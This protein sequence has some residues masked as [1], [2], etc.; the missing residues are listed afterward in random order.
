MSQMHKYIANCLSQHISV[1]YPWQVEKSVEVHLQ[2][3]WYT[4]YKVSSND[5][6]IRSHEFIIYS[7]S[8]YASRLYL[9]ISKTNRTNSKK[10]K[11]ENLIQ[12]V[13]Y[14]WLYWLD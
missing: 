2:F 9:L 11:V 14:R 5:I 7:V 3:K 12:K 10:N 4:V 8:V 13:Q 6:I 1:V